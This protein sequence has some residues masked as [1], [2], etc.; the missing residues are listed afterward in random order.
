MAKRGE[1]TPFIK[2]RMEAFLGRETTVAELHLL[3]YIGFVMVND[4]AI[5]PE[6]INREERDILALWR[7]AGYIEGGMS[8][9]SLTREFYDFIQD[10]LFFGYVAYDCTGEI[11]FNG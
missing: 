11:E 1:L 6:K 4:R 8:G 9:L 5:K 7:A 3:P 2:A 10:I